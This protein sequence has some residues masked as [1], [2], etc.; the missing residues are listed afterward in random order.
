MG[1]QREEKV[2]FF[3]TA[4][5][6]LCLLAVQCF[7][8]VYPDYVKEERA[9]RLGAVLEGDSG[10]VSTVEKR[11]NGVFVLLTFQ[12]DKAGKSPAEILVNGEVMGNLSAG[13]LSIRGYQDDEISVVGTKGEV[14]SLLEYPQNLA[15]GFPPTVT[16]GEK[17]TFFGKVILK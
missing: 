13:I 6:F 1:F 11:E 8:Y 15:S 7:Y 16:I 12:T 5:I 9:K 3:L 2:M 10:I 17:E 4:M 14:I